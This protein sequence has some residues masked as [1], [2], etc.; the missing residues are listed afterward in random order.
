[1][2]TIRIGRRRSA[3]AIGA[4]RIEA[5]AFPEGKAVGLRV[6]LADGRNVWLDMDEAGAREMHRTLDAAIRAIGLP[7]PTVEEIG[8]WRTPGQNIKAILALRIRTHCGLK[9]AVDALKL[10]TVT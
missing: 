8:M 10:A 9:D 6:M 3:E 4:I 7:Q 5:N 1:M 2:N